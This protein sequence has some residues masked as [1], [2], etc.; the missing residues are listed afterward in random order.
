MFDYLL[1]TQL[2]DF[3]NTVKNSLFYANLNFLIS[4]IIISVFMVVLIIILINVV[5]KNK[6]LTTLFM[7]E[8]YVNLIKKLEL[9]A[10]ERRIIERLAVYL[11]DKDRKYQ[12]LI[13]PN[14]FYSCLDSLM[15]E[16]EISESTIEPVVIKLG[17]N[18]FSPYTKLVTT[19]DFY[20]GMPV[21]IVINRKDRINGRVV[22]S[23][24]HLIISV[25]ANAPGIS[26]DSMVEIFTYNQSGIYSFQ[27]KFVKKVAY[28]LYFEHSGKFTEYQRRIFF[29]KKVDLSVMVKNAHESEEPVPV[30]MLEL[31]G[32]GAMLEN[33][34]YRYDIGDDLKIR[35][36]ER[37]ILSLDAHV[38]RTLKNKSIACVEFSHL[39]QN[40]Q[41]KIIRMINKK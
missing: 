11:K 12:L 18:N 29:R 25:N 31:S 24:K 19:H 4:A 15:N 14:V 9:T 34:N 36:P 32:S 16:D 23:E 38:V 7:R 17:F 13:N 5:Y 20:D 41:D 30:K 1:T 35:F 3:F 26:E 28:N 33:A 21:Y 40:V 6:K 22:K 10:D 39:R 8:R 2:D 37:D 27:T